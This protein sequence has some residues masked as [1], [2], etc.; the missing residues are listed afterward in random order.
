[1]GTELA[2]NH[3]KRAQ[4]C[5][6]QHAHWLGKR[7]SKTEWFIVRVSC[8]ATLLHLIRKI[9]H[10]QPKF[11]M[12]N[13]NEIPPERKRD[14]R[15]YCAFTTP[16]MEAFFTQQ[17]MNMYLE[18]ALG[19]L[20]PMMGSPLWGVMRHHSSATATWN[21][22]VVKASTETG[23]VKHYEILMKALPGSLAKLAWNL[24]R[25]LKWQYGEYGLWGILQ[26]CTEV[27]RKTLQR[28]A[29]CLLELL[30]SL[31]IF[32]K[33]ILLTYYDLFDQMPLRHSENIINEIHHR[34]DRWSKISSNYYADVVNFGMPVSWRTMARVIF[35][36]TK[37][38]PDV[39]RTL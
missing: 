28:V 38:F 26:C 36:S 32:Y 39:F 4:E 14:H 18:S 12:Q 3:R 34:I 5:Y 11:S 29:H 9:R 13:R 25:V 27:L 30:L 24:W 7:R 20:H 2:A 1:M 21:P 33:C 19:A 37:E 16:K 15:Y 8:D 23:A 35:C 22:F 17:T 31:L 10:D 6:M